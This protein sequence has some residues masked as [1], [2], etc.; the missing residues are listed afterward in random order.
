[1]ENMKKEK[2]I[3]PQN[4]FTKVRPTVSTKEA[5]KDVIPVEWKLKEKK[6]KVI[7]YSTRERKKL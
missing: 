4:F 7:A 3:L 6:E 5:L 1:M 2:I